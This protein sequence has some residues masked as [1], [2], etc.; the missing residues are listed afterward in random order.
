MGRLLAVILPRP[1][2]RTFRWKVRRADARVCQARWQGAL[3]WR[4]GWEIRPRLTGRA[5]TRLPGGEGRPDDL[6]VADRQARTHRAQARGRVAGADGFDAAQTHQERRGGCS[7]CHDSPRILDFA[8]IA[9]GGL[10]GPVRRPSGG[11]TA[12]SLP[13]S[14]RRAG[15]GHAAGAG[16]G[17][18]GRACHG[19][20]PPGRTARGCP[21]KA[22]RSWR[23]AC[24]S[25]PSKNIAHR[26]GRDS[27]G[28]SPRRH[29]PWRIRS[30]PASK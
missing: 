17:K 12:A 22:V 6:P 11:S 20:R 23:L 14:A 2:Q 9:R 26:T 15:K 21:A 3:R 1:D 29:P 10:P 27:P 7:F 18:P 24:R 25:A 5:R 16:A 4:R 8:E 19:G 13:E 28:G 30:P